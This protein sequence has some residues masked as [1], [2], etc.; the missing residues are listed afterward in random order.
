MILSKNSPLWG[1]LFEI[2]WNDVIANEDYFVYKHQGP[3][4]VG[5]A[6]FLVGQTLKQMYSSNYTEALF[7]RGYGIFRSGKPG[8]RVSR[9]P[10]CPFH[11]TPLPLP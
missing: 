6:G 11:S 3:K 9:V 10:S 7:L 4:V 2:G 8:T 1:G 5:V